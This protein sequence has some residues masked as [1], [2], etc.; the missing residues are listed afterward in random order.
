MEEVREGVEGTSGGRGFQA[1][2]TASAKVLGVEPWLV[3]LRNK[4][5]ADGVEQSE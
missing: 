2:E 3:S 4:E 5:E 1:E